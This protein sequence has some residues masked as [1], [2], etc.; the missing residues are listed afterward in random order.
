MASV[1][2][3]R[4]QPV[5]DG[6]M[7]LVQDPTPH[8][9]LGTGPALPPNLLLLG[10]GGGGRNAEHTPKAAV[11][12]SRDIARESLSRLDNPFPAGH[13]SLTVLLISSRGK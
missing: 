12:D 4:M 11:Q 10:W 2:G 13:G 9:S 5:P 6:Q 7:H 1:S 3:V 8:S